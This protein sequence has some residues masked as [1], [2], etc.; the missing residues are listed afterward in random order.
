MTNHRLYR[1]RVGI[2]TNFAY[3]QR[4]EV[5]NKS[6]ELNT[7]YHVRYTLRDPLLASMFRITDRIKDD[8]AR[9]F[10]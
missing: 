4:P 10:P 6:V 9:R 2:N 7:F 8:Q 1:S 3:E 5:I